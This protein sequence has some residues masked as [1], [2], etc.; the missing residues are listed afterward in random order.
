MARKKIYKWHRWLS[1]MAAVPMIMWSVSGMLH[2]AGQWVKPKLQK[3]FIAVKVDSSMLAISLDSA[4]RQNCFGKILTSRVVQYRNEFFYQVRVKKNEPNVYISAAN[5]EILINGDERYAVALTFK[6]LG[7]ENAHIGHREFITAFNEHY[8]SPAK[9]LPVYGLDIHDDNGTHLYIDTYAG[10]LTFASNDQRHAFHTW[11]GYLHSW[12]FLDRW[13]VAKSAALVLYSLI[14]FFAAVLGIYL[15][16]ILPAIN[17]EKRQKNTLQR[18]RNYHR[19]VGIFASFSMLLFAFSGALH[20][21]VDFLPADKTSGEP[22]HK[23][24]FNQLHMFRFTDAVGKDFR[25]WLLMI[26]AFINLLTVMTGLILVTRFVVKKKKEKR[27]VR[28]VSLALQPS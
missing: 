7:N 17:R 24:L 25:F 28:R 1:L 4:L 8:R 21:F 22:W 27:A 6:M 16:L 12:K 19:W 26:F 18:R 20:A 14:A 9:V 15:Y 23:T 3:E 11:F 5:G 2:Q 13:P 10:R